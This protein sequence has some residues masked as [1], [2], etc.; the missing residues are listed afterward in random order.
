MSV[1]LIVYLG[2]KVIDQEMDFASMTSVLFAMVYAI[3][4]LRRV[5]RAN[6]HIQ[7]EHLD[8]TVTFFCQNDRLLCRAAQPVTVDHRPMQPEKGLTLDQPIQIGKLSMVLAKF[9][10]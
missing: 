8:E 9:H 3:G 6:N 7:T 2:F 5:A 10:T 4:P 1:I